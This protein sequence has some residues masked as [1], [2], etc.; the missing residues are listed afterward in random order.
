MA[1]RHATIERNSVLLLALTLVTVAIGGLVEI[2][3]LFAVETTIERVAGV[4]PYTPL[5]LMGR[6]IYIREGCYVCH[7]QMVRPLRDEVERYGHYSLAAREHVRPPVPVG[8]E[9]HRAGSGARRRQ[10]L[11]R[12]ARRAHGGAALRRAGVD[13]AVLS[14]PR[15]AARL[16]LDRRP[17]QGE[18]DRRRALH[19]GDD[20]QRRRRPRGA[21]QPDASTKGLLER[22]PKAVVAAFDGDPARI[23][24]MDA[25]LAYL[26]ML[27]TLVKFSDVKP[28]QLRQ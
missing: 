12:M 6:N 10:V 20:R 16:R 11:E 24:E 18:P 21:E 7:S 22:Y 5:E 9:A 28:E 8:L 2:V 15:P 3:P 27:G 1:F 19:R 17:P 4:R 26:Q 14:V 23:T 25:L 13:H